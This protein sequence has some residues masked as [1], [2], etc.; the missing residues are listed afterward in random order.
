M[1]APINAYGLRDRET[2]TSQMATDQLQYVSG[3]GEL[4]LSKL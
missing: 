4:M 1:H 3:E 2:Y